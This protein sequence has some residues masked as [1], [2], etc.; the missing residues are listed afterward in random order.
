M[1]TSNKCWGIC[2]TIS[3]RKIYKIWI[4]RKIAIIEAAKSALDVYGISNNGSVFSIEG[5]VSFLEIKQIDCDEKLISIVHQE[6]SFDVI[7]FFI[8]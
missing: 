2:S 8:M 7:D 4:W 6:C 1:K 5:K 3:S